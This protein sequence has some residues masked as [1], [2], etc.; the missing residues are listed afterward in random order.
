ME[1]RMRREESA[2]SQAWKSSLGLQAAVLPATLLQEPGRQ[3]HAWW[4]AVNAEEV[5]VRTGTAVTWREAATG[6]QQPDGATLQ[7]Q[8]PELLLPNTRLLLHSLPKQPDGATLQLQ[9]PELLLPNTRLLLH[10]LPKQVALQPIDQVRDQLPDT[11][12]SSQVRATPPPSLPSPAHPSAFS[13]V[14]ISVHRWAGKKE[15][16][17][18]WVFFLSLTAVGS[19]ALS[20]SVPSQPPPTVDLGYVAAKEERGVRQ[21]SQFAAPSGSPPLPPSHQQQQQDEE[22]EEAYDSDEPTTLGTLEF[23]LTYDQV[24]NALHCTIVRAK[25]EYG[26]ET[27]ERGRIL[28]SL[29]YSSQQG[30]LIVEIIRC[31]HLAAMDANGYSDPFVKMYANLSLFATC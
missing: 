21:S 7:L 25:V 11:P 31:V 26:A 8:A 28:I 18:S 22:D 13:L 3:S 17:P 6:A 27:E 19:P 16:L 24:N 12:S 15:R 5:R 1:I 14:F 4:Q 23:S 9:A 20:H 2:E 10:S 30:G 29:L